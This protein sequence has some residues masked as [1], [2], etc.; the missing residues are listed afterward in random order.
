[1]DLCETLMVTTPNSTWSPK[2]NQASS[3]R[4]KIIINI[5][6]AYTKDT[7]KCKNKSH[8]INFQR[9][10]S[11]LTNIFIFLS[12][13]LINRQ[14]SSPKTNQSWYKF[15]KEKK[16]NSNIECINIFS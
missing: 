7:K 16:Q 12:S 1:M 15:S 13:L 4:T 11:P 5:L 9:I 14:S 6:Y 10:V 8:N 2:H 3:D